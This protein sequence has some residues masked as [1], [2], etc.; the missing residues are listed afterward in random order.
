MHGRIQCL[1]GVP[2][3]LRNPSRRACGP[4]EKS[5]KSVLPAPF[6]RNFRH[7]KCT[8]GAL[9]AHKGVAGFAGAC[10]VESSA[11]RTRL[12]PCFLAPFGQRSPDDSPYSD[13]TLQRHGMIRLG[14][15]RCRPFVV[16]IRPADLAPGSPAG[17]SESTVGADLDIPTPP[18][19]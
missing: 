10:R 3:R 14:T 2:F 9:S 19:R 16:F 13:G 7:K 17:E 8:V 1:R 15:K 12:P 6:A 18:L 11:P 5:T 4:R